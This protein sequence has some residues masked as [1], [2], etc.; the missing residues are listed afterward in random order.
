MTSLLPK[1]PVVAKSKKQFSIL[2]LPA[3]W[4]QLTLTLFSLVSLKP[5]FSLG[6]PLLLDTPPISSGPPYSLPILS[7]GVPLHVIRGPLLSSS[8]SSRI[9]LQ[10][11]ESTLAILSGRNI[12]TERREALRVKTYQAEPSQPRPN[13]RWEP[14]AGRARPCLL[15]YLERAHPETRP[16]NQ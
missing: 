16:A 10:E 12:K 14:G 7:A 15:S 3:S 13:S 9:H 1:F 5:R 2:I 4:Q 11:K 8:V 6:F